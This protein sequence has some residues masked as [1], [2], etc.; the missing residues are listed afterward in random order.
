MI[1][2]DFKKIKGINWV[3]LLK[4]NKYSFISVLMLAFY[5]YATFF[6]IVFIV[7]NVRRAFDIDEQA[8]ERTV[9]TFDTEGYAQIARRFGQSNEPEN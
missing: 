1:T 5:F 2:L 7:K 8:A 3:L 6:A 4:Q 9:T